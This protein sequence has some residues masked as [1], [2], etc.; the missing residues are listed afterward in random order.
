M[1]LPEVSLESK[2]KLLWDNGLRAY[3]INPNENAEV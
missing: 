2:R 1:E 3:P